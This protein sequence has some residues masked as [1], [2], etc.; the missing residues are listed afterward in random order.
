[1]ATPLTLGTMMEKESQNEADILD[2]G[3]KMENAEN[4][5][6]ENTSQFNINRTKSVEAIER[7][8]YGHAQSAKIM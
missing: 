8:L 4:I 1:M 5:S 2:T 3:V 6:T 7:G